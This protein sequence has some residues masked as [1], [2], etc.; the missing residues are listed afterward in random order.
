MTV[1]TLPKSSDT[2]KDTYWSRQEGIL[3]PEQNL[4]N[5]MRV[6]ALPADGPLFAYKHMKGSHQPQTRTVFLDRLNEVVTSLHLSSIKGHGLRIEGTLEYLFQGVPFNIVKSLGCWNSEAFVLYL[7]Q[8]AVIMAPYLQ[9]LPVLEPFTH[10][11]MLPI[12]A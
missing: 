5:H 7:C 9:N 3:D 4:E 11:T 2:P 1:F 12:A 10:Y 6:N 8:H